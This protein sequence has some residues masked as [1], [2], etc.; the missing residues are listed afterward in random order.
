MKGD[1][2]HVVLVGFV[3]V[4][5]ASHWQ[6]AHVFPVLSKGVQY[7]VVMVLSQA[8]NYGWF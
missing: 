4:E 7:R 2:Q 5:S 1:V 6:D 3:P 8:K